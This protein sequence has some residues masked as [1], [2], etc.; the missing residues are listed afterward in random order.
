MKKR[1]KTKWVYVYYTLIKDKFI[2][3]KKCFKSHTWDF[4]LSATRFIHSNGTRCAT[5]RYKIEFMITKNQ[6]HVPWYHMHPVKENLKLSTQQ[7]NFHH[8]VTT[9]IES[10]PIHITCL[11]MERYNTFAPSINI[12]FRFVVCH[13]KHKPG[14][15][16]HCW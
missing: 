1:W 14:F 4:F 13:C 11:Y 6:L 7:L 9:V 3:I 2:F 10:Y 15:A 8:L 5:D 12:K 16:C